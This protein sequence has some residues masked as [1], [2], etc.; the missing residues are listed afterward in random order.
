VFDGFLPKLI[1]EGV[2]Y[3]VLKIAPADIEMARGDNKRNAIRSFHNIQDH[4]Q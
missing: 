4:Y 1:I 3:R 2:G